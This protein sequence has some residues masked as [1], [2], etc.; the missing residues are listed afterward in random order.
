MLK[1]G[2]AKKVC[3]KLLSEA[4][5]RLCMFDVC[6]QCIPGTWPSDGKGLVSYMKPST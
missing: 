3:L 4:A 2:R 1:R 5:T 6:G